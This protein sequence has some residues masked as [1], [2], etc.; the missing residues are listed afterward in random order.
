MGQ[1]GPFTRSPRPF[2]VPSCPFEGLTRHAVGPA[3]GPPLP[4]LYYNRM[5]NVGKFIIVQVYYNPFTPVVCCS[6]PIVCNSWV[7]LALF[8]K[9][10]FCCWGH[11]ILKKNKLWGMHACNFLLAC[12]QTSGEQA[13][14]V[15]GTPCLPLLGPQCPFAPKKVTASPGLGAPQSGLGAGHGVCLE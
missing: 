1:C 12:P 10:V 11:D 7:V 5:A 6:Q 15:H 14:N 13:S 4:Y 8:V 2:W 9:H 3:R